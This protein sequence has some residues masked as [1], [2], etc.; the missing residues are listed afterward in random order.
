MTED[1]EAYKNDKDLL[2]KVIKMKNTLK[3]SWG[4]MYKKDKATKA[5]EAE[6]MRSIPYGLDGMN[7]AMD[8]VRDKIRVN[9][10]TMLQTPIEMNK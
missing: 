10:V 6:E 7:K 3:K 8:E 1:P 2:E 4:A 5:K 9:F